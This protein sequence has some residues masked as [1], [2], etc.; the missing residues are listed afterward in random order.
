MSKQYNFKKEWEITKKK[1]IQFSKEAAQVAKK[2]EKELIKFSRKGKL[3]VDSTAI[4][5][6]K[7]HL[8]YLIGKEYVKQ[9]NSAQPTAALKKL[10]EEYRKI[11]REQFSL[12]K[13]IRNFKIKKSSSSLYAGQ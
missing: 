3:H 9:K 10:I 8:Y 6:K 2:G 13:K 4:H 12:K 11:H 5:L 7:E 1:L